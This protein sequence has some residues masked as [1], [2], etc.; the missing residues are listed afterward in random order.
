MSAQRNPMTEAPAPGPTSAAR[1][2]AEKVRSA[3]D[4]LK[5]S[6]VRE[7]PLV[8]VLDLSHQMADAMKT[9]F[10]SLDRSIIGEFRYIADFI[11]KAR[12]EIS[13]LQANDIKDSRIP[14]ASMELDAVVRDTERATE[15]IMSE[16]EKL[17]AA[18]PTDL[19]LYKA[20]VGA[21]MLRIFEACSFQDLTGQRVNKVIATL[22]HIEE[23]VAQFAGALGVTDTGAAPPTAAEQRAK[24]LLLNGPAING[25]A[26]TQDDIDAMFA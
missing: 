26:T 10:G 8:E 25:P 19:E 24:D 20:E 23:R 4:T 13:G 1:E 22:R 16:G 5:A 3:I 21:A 6:G 14:G 9:F 11:Q 12:D 15:T 7:R 17:M 18:E 2:A